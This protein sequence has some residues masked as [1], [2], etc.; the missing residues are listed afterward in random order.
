MAADSI[1]PA[2]DGLHRIRTKIAAG[3]PPP[4]QMT[5]PVA[6]YTRYLTGLLAMLDV[7]ARHLE[8]A[9]IRIRY[10]FGAVMERF[11]PDAGVPGWIR[12][13][14]PAAALATTLLVVTGASWAIA[15][16]PQTFANAGHSSTITG[17]GSST[18]PPSSGNSGSVY[19]TGAPVSQGSSAPTSS[20]SCNTS[21]GSPTS[22]SPSPSDSTSP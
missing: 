14:R 15:A 4:I 18:S 20:P 21:Q 3:P 8:P 5:S 19:G 10:A 13:T 6:W 17:G 12:W 7:A 1:E 2:G 16:L 9:G 11:R 22:P